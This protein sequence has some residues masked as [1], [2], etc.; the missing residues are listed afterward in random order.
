[1]NIKNTIR[2][3]LAERLLGLAMNI[4]SK[5]KTEQGDAMVLKI[6]E[7]FKGA[8]KQSIKELNSVKFTPVVDT[9]AVERKLLA[10]EYLVILRKNIEHA[11][12]LR[13]AGGEIISIYTTGRVLIQG[14]KNEKL[15]Q[16]LK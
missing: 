2:L 8:I 3:V 16:L 11:T 4:A 14:K 12:Q 7:Y 13:L 15:N 5:S 6:G 1:M 10:N 9:S